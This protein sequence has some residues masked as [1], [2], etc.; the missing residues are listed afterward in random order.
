MN[1]LIKTQFYEYL[2]KF[3]TELGKSSKKLK[4]LIETDYKDIRNEECIECIRKN[5]YVYKTQFL[6]KE[7]ELDEF[8]EKTSVE[9]LDKINISEIWTKSKSDNKN[10]IIQYIKVFVFMF[11]TATKNETNSDNNDDKT[12]E[13][14]V[15]N[16]DSTSENDE[17]NTAGATPNFEDALKDS[18]LNNDENL[19]SFCNSLNEEDN[20]IVNLAKNIAD[21]LKNNNQ[22][23]PENLMNMFSGGGGGGGGIGNLINTI[24]SKLDSDIKS[25]KLDQNKL[26]NDAQKMMGQN[27]SLFGDLLNNMNQNNMNF[28]NGMNFGNTQ[29]SENA[30][31]TEPKKKGPKKKKTTNKK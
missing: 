12:D 6:G 20:S 1:D 22:G 9:L 17:N 3:L 16:E 30:E 31:Q 2:E 7:E 23:G 21:D 8:F 5:I 13:E 15:E 26:L 24:T 10:A 4:K 28:G 11:E 18:L 14:C 19:K 25:G 29:P 27:N